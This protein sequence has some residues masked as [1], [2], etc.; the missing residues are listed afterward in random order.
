[1]G[2]PKATIRRFPGFSFDIM[3]DT[4]VEQDVKVGLFMIFAEIINKKQST[5][6][7]A[8]ES[9]RHKINLNKL[10][11]L[12]IRF[13]KHRPAAFRWVGIRM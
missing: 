2:S 8:I 1:M 4:A 10:R 9:L 3:R 12:I 13:H 11:P 7:K 6:L 5:V